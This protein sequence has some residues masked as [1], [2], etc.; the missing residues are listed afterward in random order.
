MVAIDFSPSLRHMS[1][2]NQSLFR[3]LQTLPVEALQS[4]ST[5]PDF[6]VA[7]ILRHIVDGAEWY[8]YCLTGNHQGWNQVHPTS[9]SDVQ[10]LAE[11]LL[12]LDAIL[13]SQGARDDEMLTIVEDGKTD[14]FLLST[15]IAQS[16]H[17]ATEHRAQ[18]VAALELRGYRPLSL[19]DVDL[20]SF[21]ISERPP[22]D[23]FI[24]SPSKDR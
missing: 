23:I 12:E 4:Y 15:V 6:D 2:A 10:R 8:C 7:T 3:A 5:N 1:W 19:D 14:H 11:T 20:W 24:P 17:H 22:G 13:L 18:I 16:T 21:E 9:L